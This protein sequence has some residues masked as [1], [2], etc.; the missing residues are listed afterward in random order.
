MMY[1]WQ[2]LQKFTR[3]S[4]GKIYN[5]FDAGPRNQLSFI[6]RIEDRNG[7]VLYETKKKETQLVD[8]CYATQISEILRKVVTHGT[9]K[10]ARGSCMLS[11]R[12]MVQRV[13]GLVCSCS[14][15]WKNG[16]TNDYRTA[17]FAGYVLFQ[18]SA[19]RL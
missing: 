18:P 2:K 13:M 7:N 9:G 1:Q 17:Y 8:E 6:K 12:T 15:L 11:L 4:N 3:F 16:T 10:R 19:L 5:F 14:R